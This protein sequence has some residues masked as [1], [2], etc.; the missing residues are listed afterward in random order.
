MPRERE[1]TR[2]NDAAIT[3]ARRP[4]QRRL[5]GESPEELRYSA[6]ARRA[7]VALVS[8]YLRALRRLGEVPIAAPHPEMPH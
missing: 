8:S 4:A 3:R 6:R 5:T 1:G 7:E 2:T